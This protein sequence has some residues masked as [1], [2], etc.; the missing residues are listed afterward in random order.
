M[1]EAQTSCV[2]LNV[3]QTGTGGLNPRHRRG[4]ACKHIAGHTGWRCEE[5]PS[6]PGR[7]AERVLHR[8]CIVYGSLDVLCWNT[9]VIKF[10]DGIL[11]NDLQAE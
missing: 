10:A 2:M 5:M 8:L 1:Q 11:C 6:W 7:A 4:S 9:D 3:A